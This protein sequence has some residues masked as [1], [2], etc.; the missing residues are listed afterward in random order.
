M[1]VPPG[2]DVSLNFFFIAKKSDISCSFFSVFFSSALFFIHTPENIKYYV[3]HRKK[4][5]LAPSPRIM[6]PMGFA[7]NRQARHIASVMDENSMYGDD[8]DIDMSNSSIRPV[9]IWLC[10]FLVIGYI[11]GGA[12]FFSRSEEWNFLDAAYFCFITLTT[13]G[14]GDFVP[15]QVS[16]FFHILTGMECVKIFV[17]LFFRSQRNAGDNTL[18]QQSIAICSLY[19]LFGIALLAMSFNLVQEEVI[20]KV[21]KVAKSL[22]IIK[23]DEEEQNN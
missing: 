1:D 2:F 20:A 19:L 5:A 13:I 14:F 16:F 8:D 11:L 4:K 12:Y 17:L 9:P 7:I 18:Q 10:V 21:K 3:T 15:A 23:P 6:S 22:G